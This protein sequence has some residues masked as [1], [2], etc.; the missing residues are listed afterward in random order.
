ME[1]DLKNIKVVLN[2]ADE[3]GKTSRKP[4]TIKVNKIKEVSEKSMF[5]IENKMLYEMSF[6]L[7]IPEHIHSSLIGKTTPNYS[8]QTFS[9]DDLKSFPT[10]FSKTIKADTIKAVCEQYYSILQSYIWL[11]E[12]ENAKLER[13]IFYSFENL[14][15]VFKSSW[16]GNEF[17]VNSNLDFKLCFGYISYTK[18][19][20]MRYNN[21]KKLINEHR[22]RD[23]YKL[24]YVSWTEE[25]ELFFKNILQTFVNIQEKLNNFESKLNEDTIQAIMSTGFLMLK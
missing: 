14:T 11:K 10:D 13:V 9:N 18:N 7:I 16:N 25:R 17:G 5:S 22:D 19:S 8:K 12:I 3:N 20:I 21:D 6:S 2:Y 1:E 23:F 15:D 24:K 4:M